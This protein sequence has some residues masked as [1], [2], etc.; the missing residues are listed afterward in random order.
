VDKVLF[1]VIMIGS[2]WVLLL[3]FGI[4]RQTTISLTSAAA[5][6]PVIVS[7]LAGLAVSFFGL[8]A[9]PSTYRMEKL[10]RDR[11]GAW[12]GTVLLAGLLSAGACHFVSRGIMQVSAQLLS[13]KLEPLQARVSKV[14]IH[15][16]SAGCRK[17]VWVEPPLSPPFSVCFRVK[18]R[19]ALGPDVTVGA[20]VT[21]Q[22]K[23]T[24]LGS[25][26]TGLELRTPGK[27]Q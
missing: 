17:T 16:G 10:K 18:W 1:P 20:E 22:I 7:V 4:D 5:N 14:R 3:L 11:Y 19:D 12:I 27:G 21:L 24:A 8:R 23:N 2:V 9:S 25:V 26:V 6:V 13:G 15:G